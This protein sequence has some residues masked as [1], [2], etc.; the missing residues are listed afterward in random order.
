VVRTKEIYDLRRRGLASIAERALRRFLG[1]LP[2]GAATHHRTCGALRSTHDG[3]QS[4]RPP[5]ISPRSRGRMVSVGLASKRSSS[6]PIP[7]SREHIRRSTCSVA[8][9]PFVEWQWA[10]AAVPL[11]CSGSAALSILACLNI[12]YGH[13]GLVRSVAFA[14]DDATL[15]SAGD[16]STVRLWDITTGEPKKTLHGH[17]G[18]VRSVAFSADGA[19]L[20]SAGLTRPSSSGTS[21]LARQSDTCPCAQSATASPGH[22]TAG[23]RSPRPQRRGHKP[24]RTAGGQQAAQQL[25]AQ[26]VAQLAD[27]EPVEV[28]HIKG[29]EHC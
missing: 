18:P 4:P 3:S 29:N 20:A 10:P 15:A 5:N 17:E 16:D 24:A 14:A 6:R 2:A 8:Q 7:Y 25:A 28:Q 9:L 22:A 26:R 12:L 27:R 19:T 21:L 13:I 1:R 23:W 11:P